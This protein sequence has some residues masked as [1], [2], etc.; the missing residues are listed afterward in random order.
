MEDQVILVN[1]NDV[2]VGVAGKM[3]AHRRGDLHRAVSVFIFDSQGRL[4]LQK[5]ASAKYHSAGLWSN[6]CCSHPRPNETSAN[7]ARRCLV[8]EMGIKCELEKVFS[9][10]YRAT[11]GNGLFEHEYDH[12]FFG[13][14]DGEP[15]L[16]PAEAEEWKWVE[17]T[18][19]SVDVQ[20]CPE[21]YSFW[22]L[23]CLEHVISHRSS[24]EALRLRRLDII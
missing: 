13:N 20:R 19:L 11:F 12:V 7:A 4:M 6:T 5:R 22:L 17:I 1:R 3:L 15:L 18:E 23:A 24:G 10:V 16:N 14:Y 9:F 2:E 8:E 21:A